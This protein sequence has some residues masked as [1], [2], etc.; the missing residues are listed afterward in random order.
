MHPRRHIA[1][2]WTAIVFVQNCTNCLIKATPWVLHLQPLI[3]AMGRLKNAFASFIFPAM[4]SSSGWQLFPFYLKGWKINSNWETF[5]PRPD[6]WINEHQLSRWHKLY[7]PISPTG[8]NL[9][10][11]MT[12][13][14]RSLEQ[15]VKWGVCRW[16][17]LYFGGVES[18][19]RGSNVWLIAITTRRQDFRKT[20]GRLQNEFTNSKRCKA[21]TDT[22]NMEYKTNTG[23][24]WCRKKCWEC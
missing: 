4:R 12:W 2:K 16:L 1:M 21:G 10:I 8:E 9:P 24:W 23:L 18:G 19:G 13:L 20:I 22:R 15:K 6:D 11:F 17:R 5:L 7:S 14:G 3:R